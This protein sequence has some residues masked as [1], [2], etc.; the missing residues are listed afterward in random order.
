MAPNAS[1]KRAA[2]SIELNPVAVENTERAVIP[3]EGNLDPQLPEK[4]LQQKAH[5]I[6][7]F[8]LLGCAVELGVRRLEDAD[9]FPISACISEFPDYKV[10]KNRKHR[11][12]D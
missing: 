3:S 8:H 12:V 5:F 7:E 11:R 1:F 6:V 2:G 9:F 4:R 10:R